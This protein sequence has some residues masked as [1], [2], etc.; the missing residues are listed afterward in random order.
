MTKTTLCIL[1]VFA[2]LW[3]ASCTVDRDPCLL[4]T[5]TS[6]RLGAYQ[7]NDSN[8]AIIDSFL[9][10]PVWIAIDSARGI[11]FTDKT[12]KFSLRLSSVTDSCRYALQPDSAIAAFDTLTFYYDRHLQFLS[13]PCGYTH[14]FSLKH[15]RSTYHQ[16]DSV[17]I[18]NAE[19][20]SDANSPEHVQIY[21]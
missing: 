12:A 13:N 2:G 8:N 1:F 14:Y 16:V 4:P 17:R 15:I 21:F 18:S 11:Q 10:K 20:N 7:V 3:T 5:N 19:V 6:L 9:P